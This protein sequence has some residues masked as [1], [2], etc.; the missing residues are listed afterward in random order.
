MAK[1][2]L[3]NW[4]GV[5][6]AEFRRSLR[7]SYAKVAF[8]LTLGLAALAATGWLAIKVLGAFPGAWPVTSVLAAVS[9]GYWM[10]YLQLFIHE[11]A[12]FNLLASRFWNDRLG[13]LLIGLWVGVRLENYRAIHW[14]HHRLHGEP[15]DSEHSYFFALNA[16]F[17]LE[18]LFG[19]KAVRVI[20]FRG[21]RLATQF[22]GD[23]PARTRAGRSMLAYTILLH[24][25]II[26]SLLAAGQVL[27][28]AAWIAGM[29]MFFPF[30]GALRQLLEHRSASASAST[31]YFAMPHGRTT[32]IFKEGIFS[33]TFG[34][35]GFT[36]H[37]LHHW[38]P[39][40]SYTNLSQ[41]ENFLANCEPTRDIRR[42]KTT[43]LR[44]F[45]DLYDR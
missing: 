37:P 11:A 9:F 4:Q 21:Q 33:S 18:A 27:V 23:S 41:V 24:L 16:S 6:Y 25:M 5:S 10:A 42:R 34:G 12:H 22:A 31:N 3:K 32:R 26:G 40:V 7:P 35:A 19:I 30:F 29:G 13:N 2:A 8:D 1:T 39:S 43:Y 45:L 38:D 20:L 28:A 14:Q 17:L 36:R 15:T 44:A